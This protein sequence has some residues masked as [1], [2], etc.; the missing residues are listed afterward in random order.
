MESVMRATLLV[1]RPQG[2]DAR[3]FEITRVLAEDWI[4]SDNPY[5]G[6]RE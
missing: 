1:E 6:E 3:Q 2:A 5:D 4:V